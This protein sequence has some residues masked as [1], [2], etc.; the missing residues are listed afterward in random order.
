MWH[1]LNNNIIY[2]IRASEVPLGLFYEKE[3]G[4][5]KNGAGDPMLIKNSQ[6]HNPV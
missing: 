1:I 4:D 6:K 3:G 2:F 5:I